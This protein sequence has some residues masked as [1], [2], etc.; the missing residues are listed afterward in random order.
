MTEYDFSPEAL[1]R[2]MATQRRI[3]HW[4]DQ[5][6][7]H[8]TEF[9]AARESRKPSSSQHLRRRR[10]RNNKSR[11]RR[12]STYSSS[13]SS[14]RQYPGPMPWPP[15][16]PFPY[17]AQPQHRPSHS[18]HHSTDHQSSSHRAVD[19]ASRSTSRPAQVYPYPYGPTPGSGQPAFPGPYT[20]FPQAGVNSASRPSYF[21]PNAGHVF[22][23]TSYM[24]PQNYSQRPGSH[25]PP[26]TAAP[27]TYQYSRPHPTQPRTSRPVQHPQ[28]A[29]YP[30]TIYPPMA[31]NPAQQQQIPQRPVFYRRFF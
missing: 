7:A 16:N 30:P 22:Q 4:V 15:Q 24:T 26:Q 9:G 14:T 18:R 13:S 20:P 2:Y 12:A 28:G 3:A 6:E 27:P 11:P 5:T 21:Q 19:P 8:R 17:M 23:S 10:H 1:E 31:Y 29:A 25:Y